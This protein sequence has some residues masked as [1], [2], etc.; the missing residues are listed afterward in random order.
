[1][2][3]NESEKFRLFCGKGKSYEFKT[4]DG[5]TASFYFEPLDALYIGDLLELVALAQRMN[6]AKEQSSEVIADQSDK[7]KQSLNNT[8]KQGEIEDIALSKEYVNKAVDLIKVMIRQ[9]YDETVLPENILNK[10]V[11]TNYL[12]LLEILFELNS[13]MGGEQLSEES[14][15]KINELKEKIKTNETPKTDKV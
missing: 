8:K 5:Q 6:A 1:M 11:A 12:R 2:K 7:G 9:T 14:Q 4:Q 10:F 13:S 15:A 3:M